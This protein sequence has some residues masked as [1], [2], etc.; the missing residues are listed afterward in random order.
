VWDEKYT[1]LGV[2]PRELYMRQAGL[3]K[4]APEVKDGEV[5]LYCTDGKD[6]AET[7]KMLNP[8]FECMRC[9]SSFTEQVI[10]DAIQNDTKDKGE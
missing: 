4:L 9:V 7:S 6:K 8:T 10:K 2:T 3:C 1:K 5:V